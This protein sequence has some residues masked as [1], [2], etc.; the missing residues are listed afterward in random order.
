[1]YCAIVMRTIFQS[2][3]EAP[4]PAIMAKPYRCREEWC[5]TW[6]AW[7]ELRKSRAM[8]L[9]FASLGCA[10]GNWRMKRA[11]W[12][13]SCDAIHRRLSRRRSEDFWAAALEESARSRMG[14]FAIFRRYAPSKW[15]PWSL[16]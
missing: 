7:N 14:T 1:K 12:D 16:N 13:G 9:P 11:K 2:P 10:W 8:A 6:R 5:W 15:S 4:A 3:R